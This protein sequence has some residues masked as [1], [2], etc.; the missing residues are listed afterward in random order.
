M[1]T[2]QNPSS[3]SDFIVPA[4]IEARE[5]VN[6]TPAPKVEAP[7]P[8]PAKSEPSSESVVEVKEG[9][10]AQVTEEVELT[11]EQK[12][13]SKEAFRRRRAEREAQQSQSKIADLERQIN[14][15]KSSKAP[16]TK[17]AVADA[18]KRPDPKDFALGRWDPKY[19][20]ALTSWLDAREEHI[21]SRATESATRATAGL[22]EQAKAVEIQAQ[23]IAKADAVESRGVDK[24]PDFLETVQ[25][26]LEAMPPAPEALKRL[27]QLPNAEDVFYTIAQNAAELE[28]ITG[29]DP[30]DQA[31]EFGKIS[32]R[33]AAKAKATAKAT[34]STPTPTTPRGDAG[35]FASESESRYDKMLKATRQW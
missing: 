11:P 28:R 16:A 10:E 33:L 7:S 1:T 25:D 5:A 34:T 30:M 6:P 35:K 26:A 22:T 8:T 2:F 13:A 29:L 12:A 3:D 14:E 24:Y 9:E 19:E 32:A 17:E 15:M 23:M 21:M 31:L 27:V 18:P 4:D 20:D